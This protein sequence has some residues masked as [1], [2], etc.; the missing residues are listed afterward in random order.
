MN[1]IS[2]GLF[3]GVFLIV[4]GLS[5]ILKVTLNINL[6]V[7]RIFLALFFIYIGISIITGGFTGKNNAVFNDVRITSPANNDEYNVIFGKGEID[8]TNIAVGTNNFKVAANTIFGSSNIYISSATPAIIKVN[9]A[10]SGVRQPDGNL[11]SF[12]NNTFR[13]GNFSEN[14]NHLI[15]EVN[16]VFSGVEIRLR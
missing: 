11:I 7:V 9:A 16:A 15:I 12:G 5:I 3:W 14:D 8:L 2:S 13:T 10:F 6:P 1:F 4:I